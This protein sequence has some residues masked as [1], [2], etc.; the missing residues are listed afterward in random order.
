MTKVY[1]MKKHST[2]KMKKCHKNTQH[3]KMRFNPSLWVFTFTYIFVIIKIPLNTFLTILRFPSIFLHLW[4]PNKKN[5]TH[6]PSKLIGLTWLS[7]SN[8]VSISWYFYFLI[9]ESKGIYLTCA[10][11]ISGLVLH[12]WYIFIF[13]RSF[14]VENWLRYDIFCL[15]EMCTLLKCRENFVHFLHKSD[16]LIKSEWKILILRKNPFF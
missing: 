13:C 9:C 16:F 12:F 3:I 7:I 11:V 6:T 15:T 8:A 10:W 1:P 4:Y 14:W 2:P 5:S